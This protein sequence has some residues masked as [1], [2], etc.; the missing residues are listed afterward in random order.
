M[1]GDKIG[2]GAEAA[3]NYLL[4]NPIVMHNTEDKIKKALLVKER[5]IKECEVEQTEDSNEHEEELQEGDE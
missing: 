4:E 2:Q 3:K 1:N 5:E